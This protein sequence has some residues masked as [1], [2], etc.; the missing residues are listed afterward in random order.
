MVAQRQA[1]LT[2]VASWNVS[3]NASSQEQFDPPPLRA[4]GIDATRDQHPKNLGFGAVRE[5]TPTASES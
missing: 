1:K 2:P 4:C 5:T 3:F